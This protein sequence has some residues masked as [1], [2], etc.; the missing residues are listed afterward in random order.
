MLYNAFDIDDR[1]HRNIG[2]CFDSSG[3]NNDLRNSLDYDDNS[4]SVAAEFDKLLSVSVPLVQP[5][6]DIMIY[7]C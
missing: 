2:D 1:V 5:V 7:M 3:G 6:L 4:I